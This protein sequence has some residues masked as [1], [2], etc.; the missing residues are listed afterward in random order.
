MGKY[1][2]ASKK[3]IKP[4]LTKAGK[5]KLISNA[6]GSTLAHATYGSIIGAI[7]TINLKKRLKKKHPD[8][9]EDQINKEVKRLRKKNIREGA[10][11]GT[12]AGIGF[13][14]GGIIHNLQHYK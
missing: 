2:H 12:A 1:F 8:W 3:I 6:V 7:T 5:A 10:I 13:N 14:T 4:K 11:I 9:T